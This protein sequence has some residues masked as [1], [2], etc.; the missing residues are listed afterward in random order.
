MSLHNVRTFFF[1]RTRRVK[2][3]ANE[4]AKLLRK[5]N[6]FLPGTDF[7]FLFF[8]SFSDVA[9]M[10]LDIRRIKSYLL[11]LIISFCEP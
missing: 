1:R 10:V 4:Q 6:L 5:G 9:V 7:H 11:Q 2:K 3:I 8:Y